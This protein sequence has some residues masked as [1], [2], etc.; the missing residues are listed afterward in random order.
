[1]SEKIKPNAPFSDNELNISFFKERVKKFVEERGWSKYH[2]PKNLIQALQIEAAELS[3][4]F[5]FKER[6]YR[7]IRN[8]K[9]LMEEISDEVADIFIYLISFMNSLDMDLTRAFLQ[10]MKKNREK[11]NLKEFNNG[12]YYKK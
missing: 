6:D 3:E 10:K 11:Y 5:L 9:Q 7:E 1:M 4:L 8:D 12:K 2:H